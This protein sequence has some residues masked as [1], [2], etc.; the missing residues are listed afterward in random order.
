MSMLLRNKK[1]QGEE[2]NWCIVLNPLQNE[3]DRKRVARKISEAF[4]LSTEEALD[5]VANTPII[6]LDNLTRAIAIKVKE[7]FHLTGAELMLTNDVL[8][9]RKCYRT[10]WPEPPSLSFVNEWNPPKEAF[11]DSQALEAHEALREIR[12]LEGE[13][14]DMPAEPEEP[15]GEMTV[16]LNSERTQLLEEVDRWMKECLAAREEVSHLSQ[17]LGKIRKELETK[18]AAADKG[19][20]LGEREKE[21]RELRA[22]LANADERYEG[23]KEESRD[24]RFILE[25]KIS[26]LEAELD[27]EKQKATEQIERIKALENLKGGLERTLSEHNEKLAV[28]SDKYAAL[29]R[30]FDALQLAFEEQKGLRGLAE[31]RQKEVEASQLRLIRELESRSQEIRQIEF[32]TRELERKY[33]EL[34]ESTTQREKMLEANLK[35]LE[36]RE[37]ELESARRQLREINQQTEQREALQRRTHLAGQLVEKEVRLKTLVK[38]QEK[39]ESEIREREESM[40]KILAEQEQTEKDIIES[41]QAQRHL[42]EQNKKDRSLR[43]KWAPRGEEP[44]SQQE[45]STPHS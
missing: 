31:E 5:L 26:N 37:R 34:Q 15:V 4:S 35:H 32:N 7:Y 16:L 1:T 33:Q 41:K 44:P 43:S 6:L 22:L 9:K 21:V 8:L 38:E 12:T 19:A 23:L 36:M 25:E 13:E 29:A 11:S 17:E 40:R 14:V 30:K 3:I 39:I 27:H 42:L 2:Q 10:V 45:F 20:L 18:R 28:A 24:A